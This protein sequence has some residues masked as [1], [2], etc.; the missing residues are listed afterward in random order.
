VNAAGLEDAGERAGP[1]TRRSATQAATQATTP[2][3]RWRLGATTLALALL[4]GLLAAAPLPRDATGPRTG[5]VPRV[6]LQEAPIGSTAPVAAAPA[7]APGRDAATW[8]AVGRGLDWLAARQKEGPDGAFPRGNAAIHAPLATTAIGALAFM[9]GGSGIDRGPHGAA[10]A[11]AIDYLLARANREP[12]SAE[13]GFLA[14]PGD[15]TSRMH[16]HGYATHALAEAYAVS[17]ASTRGRLLREV[18]PL[19][20]DLIERTQGPEGAWWYDPWISV[21]H[22]G[23]VTITLVQGLRAAKSAGLEVNPRVIAAADDYVRRSQ[24]EDGTFAYHV[25]SE[26]TSVALT[27]AAIATLNATGSY[28]D[29][30]IRRGVD[31]IWR[32]LGKRGPGRTGIEFPFYERL[33]LAQAFWQLSEPSHFE[34]WFELEARYLL[35]TQRAD[36]SWE[37]TR[38]GD[39]YA[40]A[41]NTLVLAL[42]AGLLPSFTR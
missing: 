41:M 21:E 25:G 12:R 29:S 38:Y 36:G 9:A 1:P 7:P 26:R 37:D 31:A 11:R 34:R 30:A 15:T 5:G 14:S 24:V 16:G 17:T 40:T 23:S 2:R 8:A 6:P 22:E 39:A 33:Y 19:A 35:T 28:D 20:A 10:V 13:R 32:E 4:G 3:A 27:A 42:P 18:L